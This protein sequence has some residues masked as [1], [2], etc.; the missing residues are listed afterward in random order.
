MAGKR[1]YY[2]VL[3][4][5]KGASA[6][7][8]K[9]AYRKLTK[10]YH[11]DANPGDASAAEKYKEI[12]EAND[13]LS[14]PQKR[15]RYDQFGHAGDP[16]SAGGGFNGE[17]IFGG[18]GDLGDLFG[19]FFGGGRSRSRRT[20][21]NAPRRGADLEMRMR[22]DLLT[23]YKGTTREVEVPLEDNCPECGGTGA[24]PGTKAEVCPDCHG[25]GQ[26][27]H[28]VSTPFGQ[29]VQ[30]VT[31]TRCGGKGKVIASPCKKCRG[32]GRVQRKQKI[33]VTI[34]P[35]VDVDTRLRISG[36]GEAGINGGPNGDLFIS[37]DVADDR[38][39]ER[40]GADLH[41]M[42]EI[43][44]PQAALGA[45]VPVQT[46]DGNETLDV[47]AGTQSGQKLRLRGRGMPKLRGGGSGDLYIHVKVNVPKD[48]SAKARDLM[49][50]LA[51][52]MGVDVAVPKK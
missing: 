41:M 18:F 23:A 48:L 51:K 35:G 43:A 39:F 10:K 15:A 3:G 37:I 47:P 28:A 33:D 30:V 7:E 9:K 11:P 17:D 24:A 25:T 52:E 29:M 45:S 8:I 4:V 21:P 2:E 26:I 6:D 49:A 22:I 19:S 44:F 12:N 27:E 20:D 31:C 50:D 1:D 46:L 42:L 36:K 5:P 40:D 38:R 32:A 13:V 14:D 34:P 16:S